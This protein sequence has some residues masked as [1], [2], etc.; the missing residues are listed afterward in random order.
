MQVHLWDAVERRRLHRYRGHK[1][2][3]F[4]IRS[5]FGG[6]D[7]SLI[8]SGSEDTQVYIWHRYSETLLETLPGHSGSVNSVAWSPRGDL[9][10]SAS[11]DHTVR[12]WSTE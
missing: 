12:V 8:F 10:A 1:Q 4:V 5:C 11:D 7:E 9:F 6:R 3:R 2:G